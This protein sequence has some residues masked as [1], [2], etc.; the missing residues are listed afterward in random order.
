MDPLK[1]DAY[2]RAVLDVV[3]GDLGL[4]DLPIVTCMDFGHTDPIMTLPYGVEAEID[5]HKRTFAILESAV[6]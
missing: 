2:D 4:S 3:V 6:T 5:C 1:F